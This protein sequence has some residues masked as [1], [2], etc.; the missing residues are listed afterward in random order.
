M[1]VTGAAVKTEE[2]PRAL[3]ILRP[4]Q[5]GR[6]RV[7]LRFPRKTRPWPIW[8]QLKESVQFYSASI[9]PF[10]PQLFEGKRKRV[11]VKSR[12]EGEFLRDAFEYYSRAWKYWRKKKKEEYGGCKCVQIIITRENEESEEYLKRE[13][14]VRGCKFSSF[15][16][17]ARVKSYRNRSRKYILFLLQL[18]ERLNK[19][20][21]FSFF[22]RI[23]SS[24]LLN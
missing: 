23:I 18:V 13:R 5:P 4:R 15:T 11:R 14:R 24:P 7:D 12:N 21:S 19:N 10:L 8:P 1:E 17:L 3:R 20:G 22:Q 9:P 16:I 6:K 2:S